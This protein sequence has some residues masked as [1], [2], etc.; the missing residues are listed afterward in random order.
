MY[1]LE[2]QT[3]A[4]VTHLGTC[5]SKVWKQRCV[6]GSQSVVPDLWQLRNLLAAQ[7]IRLCLRLVKGWIWRLTPAPCV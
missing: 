6:S 4:Q 3:E 1:F 5:S 2:E 7:L